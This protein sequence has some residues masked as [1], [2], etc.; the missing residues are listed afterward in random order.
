MQATAL[1]FHIR[2]A[3]K[4]LARLVAFSALVLLSVVFSEIA[5][6]QQSRLEKAAQLLEQQ[7]RAGRGEFITFLL[8]AASAYR[9]DSGLTEAVDVERL[10]CPP[11]RHSIDARSYARIALEE[12]RRAKGE[13]AAL[14]EYPLDVLALALQR[15]LRA[16]YP[17]T[18]RTNRTAD[19]VAPE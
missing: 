8:G 2:G 7:A 11:P 18:D 17:C 1:F 4:M 10:F 13:Y 5:W 15:G 12:Y 14:T 9:W 19:D 6:P 3:R 16:R